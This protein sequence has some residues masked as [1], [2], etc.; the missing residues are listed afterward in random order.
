MFATVVWA[1]AAAALIVAAAQGRLT[2]L[3]ACYAMFGISLF[4][5]VII[6]TQIWSRL[7]T[8]KPGPAVMVP[9]RR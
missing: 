8:Y 7:V 4:A 3:L 9:Q 1:L 2:P 6:I 5:S